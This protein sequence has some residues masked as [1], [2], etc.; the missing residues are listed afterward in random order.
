MEF[1]EIAS[2]LL[3]F[4]L[5]NEKFNKS[6]SVAM[7]YLQLFH[8]FELISE[9]N[10][11]SLYIDLEDAR[12]LCEKEDFWEKIR[13]IVNDLEMDDSFFA[14]MFVIESSG[15][16]KLDDK[17]TYSKL[18]N[19]PSTELDVLKM[20]L[21]CS[22]SIL[23][24]IFE[25][26]EFDLDIEIICIAQ[27]VLCYDE[28]SI[29]DALDNLMKKDLMTEFI[30]GS[31]F[32]EKELIRLA[33]IPEFVRSDLSEY[34]LSEK[35][36]GCFNDG[37]L[38]V[39]SGSEAAN[40][41]FKKFNQDKI[42]FFYING[43]NDISKSFVLLEKNSFRDNTIWIDNYPNISSSH[44]NE[45]LFFKRAKLMGA[46]LVVST[47]SHHGKVF[48]KTPVE[49]SIEEN[50][51]SN[52]KRKFPNKLSEKIESQIT[53]CKTGKKYLRELE[54]IC[55]KT[56]PEFLEKNLQDVFRL[57]NSSREMKNEK[58]I[59]NTYIRIIP[60]SE[61][62]E[63]ELIFFNQNKSD[64]DEISLLLLKDDNFWREIIPNRGLNILFSGSSGCGKTEAIKQISR[65]CNRDLWFVELQQMIGTVVGED[66][67]NII[68]IFE[69]YRKYIEKSKRVPILL[70][71]ECDIFMSR[72]LQSPRNGAEISYN[73]INTVIIQCL[74]ENSQG[75]IMATTNM[76]KDLDDAYNRRFFYKVNFKPLERDSQLTLMKKYIP[77]LTEEQYELLGRKNLCPDQIR[78]IEK[79]REV[80]RKLYG[81]ETAQ[82]I[83]NIINSSFQFSEEE[84]NP[85][86][87]N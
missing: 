57:Y 33:T 2:S 53:N 82:T 3:K 30:D 58:F 43:E 22:N 80:H 49:V 86:G 83:M 34:K 10:I 7:S 42:D 69:S 26:D 20:A 47:K 31:E 85:I 65:K 73:R 12:I 48:E 14:K 38:F 28:K 68:S 24:G 60:A 40:Y 75:I 59:D 35:I 55:M 1:K 61:I 72:R 52:I 66:E 16:L 18:H 81:T 70:L 17:L 11:K 77:G 54:E 23:R 13:A 56:N 62:A 46:T 36:D 76:N 27:G 29:V 32:V 51:L 50:L 4:F 41:I 21:I 25:Y 9:F 8:N 37:G 6:P 71:N 84:S 78:Q 87:F 5:E 67:Q 63:E 15:M 44:E 64:I 19:L 39:F 45:Y 79:R 74:E